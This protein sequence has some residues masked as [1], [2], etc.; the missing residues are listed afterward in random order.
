MTDVSTGSGLREVLGQ[1]SLTFSDAAAK[2]EIP[3]RDF[4]AWGN[5]S[6]RPSKN[7]V[8]RLREVLQRERLARIESAG[9]PECDAV[10]RILAKVP[11]EL[12]PREGRAEIDTHVGSCQVCRARM[13]W[14]K[15]NLP[16]LPD[17]PEGL[18]EAI[19]GMA[20]YLPG[21]R[22]LTWLGVSLPIVIG[23]VVIAVLRA[24][25][26]HPLGGIPVYLVGVTS[27]LAIGLGLY[28][29]Q[30]F[31][32]G[33]AVTRW[34]ARVVAACSGVFAFA[35]VFMLTGYQNLLVK[36]S[37][38]MDWPDARTTAL[39]MGLMYATLWPIVT[40]MSRT[41]KERDRPR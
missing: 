8:R 37:G 6:R 5:G 12:S 22:R 10:E 19:A 38:T 28:K 23:V 41:E 13:D 18:L 15:D 26:K 35:S 21:G 24:L 7:E 32:H 36:G 9:L 14:A 1:Y 2:S 17:P 3:L 27:L 4:E 34:I 20:Q 25:P 31:L 40:A 16:P 33:N 29:A 39:A 11:G 30:F